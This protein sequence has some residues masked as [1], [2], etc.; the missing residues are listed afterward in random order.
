MTSSAAEAISSATAITVVLKLVPDRIDLPPPV[1]EGRDARDADRDVHDAGAKRPA[2]RV[3]DDDAHVAP[4]PLADLLANGCSGRVGVDGQQHE[5]VRLGRVRCV[6]AG[7]RTHEPVARLRDHERWA[8]A[9]DPRGFAEDH[10]QVARVVSSRELDG[11]SRRLDVVEANDPPLRLRHDLLGD[12]DDVAVLELDPLDDE[13]AEVVPL[14]DLREAFHR[15]DTKL[16]QRPAP[17]L[18]ARAGSR[19]HA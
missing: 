1:G 16:R 2:E 6:D 13:R 12:H 8:R 18:R 7:G 11:C 3:A 19:R 15:D 4:R 14:R 10:L 9:H 17:P 5:R